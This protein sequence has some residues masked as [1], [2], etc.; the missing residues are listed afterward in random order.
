[1]SATA[2]VEDLQ[3]AGISCEGPD[4]PSHRQAATQRTAQATIRIT[5]VCVQIWDTFNLF[6]SWEDMIQDNPFTLRALI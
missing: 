2:V 4:A 1:M 5:W 6:L 3:A